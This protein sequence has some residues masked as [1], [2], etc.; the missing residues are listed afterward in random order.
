MATMAEAGMQPSMVREMVGLSV[1]S[2]AVQVRASQGSVGHMS[3]RSLIVQP[4]E[5]G[6]SSGQRRQ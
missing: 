6:D 3:P 4:V 1:L 5:S 2:S